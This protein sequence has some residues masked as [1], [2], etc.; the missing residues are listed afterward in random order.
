[1]SFYKFIR[2][3]ASALRAL[4]GKPAMTGTPPSA[5]APIPSDPAEHAVDFSTR[6]AIE[7]DYLVSQRMLDLGIPTGQAGARDLTSGH[8]AFK[9]HETTGGGNVPGGGLTVDSGV[10][11]PDLFSDLGP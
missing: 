10:F 11:N 2:R 3:I 6:Y 4:R 5:R 9:P 8:S 1:M 7:M